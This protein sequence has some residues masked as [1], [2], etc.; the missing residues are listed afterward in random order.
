MQQP[1]EN[2]TKTAESGI[3]PFHDLKT[4]VLLMQPKIAFDIF[5][6]NITLLSESKIAGN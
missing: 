5:P 1:W 3:I 4:V 2:Q 6:S